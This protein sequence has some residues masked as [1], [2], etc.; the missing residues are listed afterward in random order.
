MSLLDRVRTLQ[1]CDWRRFRPFVIDEAIVGWIKHGFAERLRAFADVFDVEPER[2]RLSGRLTDFA[3]RTAAVGAVLEQLRAAGE[4]SGWRDERYPVDTGFGTPPLLAIERAGV[5]FFGTRSY[6]V[7][8]NGLVG[9]GAGMRL[10]VG[11]RA[12]DK[13][14]APGKL[15]HLVAG[16]VA[17]GL[18][19]GRTLVKECAEE[20]DIPEAL[21][22]QARPVG[23]VSYR[24][25][26]EQGLR[27]DVL[28]CYDLAVPE[29]F[30]PV[31][32]DGEI[33]EFFLWPIDRVRRT[34]AETDDF[35][36][37]V[38]PVII[39]LMVRHG[40]L[41]PEEPDYLAIIAGLRTTA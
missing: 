19:L 29:D 24:M 15:D 21:A 36:W 1:A 26:I 22:A 9:T 18:S 23:I 39:D 6:G 5:P 7:H 25:E 3:G 37:N 13:A 16:G 38:G 17:N 2:V 12:K 8:V 41:T 34:V 31:N 40:L 14:T 28:F 30:R 32:R 20:A 11:R 35:K 4:V 10:W 33:D 27:N